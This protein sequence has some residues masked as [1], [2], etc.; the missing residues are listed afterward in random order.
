MTELLIRSSALLNW[1]SVLARKYPPSAEI[2]D[3]ISHITRMLSVN[4]SHLR[5]DDYIN[6]LEKIA[7]RNA[8]ALAWKVGTSALMS[9]SSPVDVAIRGC[10]TL[11]AALNWSSKFFPLLQ[12][13]SSLTLERNDQWAMLCYKIQDPTIWPRHIDAV[14]TLGLHARMIK[15]ANSDAWAQ[16]QLIVEAE[17]GVGDSNLAKIVQAP[18]THGGTTNAI[19]F[20]AK[21]LDAPFAMNQTYEPEAIN[22]L[23]AQLTKKE[24][25]TPITQRT[26]LLIFLH[27]TLGS[28]SQTHI[29]KTLGLSSRTLRRRLS[30]E[31]QSFQGL[32]DLCRMQSAALDLR[33]RNNISLSEMAIK[34]GYTEHS[35][36]SRAFARWAGVPPRE[37]RN[38]FRNQSLQKQECL[39]I[40]S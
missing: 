2:E 10:K 21:Y 3:A 28:V 36:F 17:S 26:R 35:T 37:F 23:S 12:D 30:L 13:G 14:Y 8:S 7:P 32:L 22:V 29:A 38:K 18:V 4:D 39:E 5:L 40:Q 24:R 27:M 6:T 19:R 34:L 25:V 33:T 31:G 9:E 20:P 16:V 15:A 1:H 11:G